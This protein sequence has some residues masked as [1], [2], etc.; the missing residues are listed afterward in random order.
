MLREA[1]E[2]QT[3]LWMGECPI[4]SGEIDKERARGDSR[5]GKTTDG[6]LEGEASPRP[7]PKG[8]GDARRNG[9]EG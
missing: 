3:R 9:A 1:N 8:K 4:I 5:E 2:L 7:S 6:G